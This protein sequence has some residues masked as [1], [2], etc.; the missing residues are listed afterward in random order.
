VLSAIFGITGI[1]S[2]S[3]VVVA[4]RKQGRLDGIRE[5]E[6]RQIKEDVSNIKQLLGNGAYRGIRQ[7]IQQMS[8]NC[9][10]RMADFGARI[11]SLEDYNHG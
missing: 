11:K 7:D 8:V 10:K 5:T 1:G 9:A 4:I 6:L 3:G 2:L